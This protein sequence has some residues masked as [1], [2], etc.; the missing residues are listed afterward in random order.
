MS[1]ADR[2]RVYVENA[3]R[4]GI[5][6]KGS[7]LHNAN[8]SMINSYNNRLALNNPTFLNEGVYN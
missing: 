4:A 2:V 5:F 7:N 6:P 8:I 1:L 3:L